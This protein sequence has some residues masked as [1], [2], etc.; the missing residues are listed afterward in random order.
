MIIEAYEYTAALMVQL[1]EIGFF[2]NKD[3]FLEKEIFAAE[4][5]DIAHENF[6]NHESDP[7]LSEAQFDEAIDRT[8]KK[9]ISNTF[10][11]L[12]EGGL[13]QMDG[14]DKNGEFLYSLVEDNEKPTKK[15][16]K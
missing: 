3:P 9:S 14:I 12:I 7:T 10:D 8:R 13:L 16:K 1:D 15:K 4:V 2:S 6:I 11:E 5:L